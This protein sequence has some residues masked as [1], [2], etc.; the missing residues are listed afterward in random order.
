MDLQKSVS[1]RPAQIRFRN[2][3]AKRCKGQ[4]N[5]NR[6]EAAETLIFRDALPLFEAAIGL[7]FYAAM[8]NIWSLGIRRLLEGYPRGVLT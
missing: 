7:E 5:L 6:V 2:S 8:H 3:L 4:G 1:Q